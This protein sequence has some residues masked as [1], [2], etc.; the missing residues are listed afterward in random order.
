MTSREQYSWIQQSRTLL[1]DAYWPPLNPILEFDAEKLIQTAQNVN[2]NAIRFGTI[3]K[4]ALIQNDFIP[5]HPELGERDLLAE[6][7]EAAK[8][9]D[10]KIIAYV[11]VGHG[12]PRSLIQNQ[13]PD[14]RFLMDDGGIQDGVRHFGGELV[15]PVCTFGQYR[16]DI[17]SFIEHLVDDYNIDSLYLDGPYYNWNMRTQEAVCQCDICKRAFLKETGF[18]LPSNKDFEDSELHEVFDNWVGERLYKLFCDIISIAKSTKK[19]AL[20]FNAF[21]AAARPEA[22]EQQMLK[23]S[24]GFLLE[25]ELSGLRGLGVGDYH[26]KIIWRYTQAHTAWPRCSTPYA[27][28]KNKHSGYETL[29]W[30]GTPIVSYGGRLCLDN[31][32]QKPVKELFTFMKSNE[33]LLGNLQAH[34]FIGIISEQRISSITESAKQALAGAYKLLQS[35]GLRTGI[36]TNKALSDIAALQQYPVLFLSGNV[37]IS[38]EEAD[39]LREYVRQGGNLIASG[40]ASFCNDDFLLRDI[41]NISLQ[42]APEQ[43]DGLQFWDGLWDVYLQSKDSKKLLPVK[44]LTWVKGDEGT[45][46][47]AEIVSGGNSEY[48][49]QAVI[50]NSFGKGTCCYINFPIERVY[51]ELEEP[52]FI[53]IINSILDT[54]ESPCQI[55]CKHRLYSSLKEKDNLKILYMCNPSVETRNFSTRIE[56][57]INTAPTKVYSLTSGKDIKHEV[58]NEKITIQEHSFKDFDCIAITF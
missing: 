56:L 32:Y 5:L 58:K 44:E 38:R 24:D 17:L 9:T 39:S 51:D 31:S 15:A 33:S 48:L 35:A 25:A 34:K 23:K 19:L 4:Y 30:G 18:Q 45:E 13:R 7:I 55:T 50:K 10:I 54:V 3:G 37:N 26:D 49:A 57:K 20:M 47:L 12:L 53:K 46:C 52:E 2:G 43:L 29:T 42:G 22:W 6:T 16:D 11:A 36:V 28:K 14:W 8:G 21:A 1:I 40:K 27:E 41:F